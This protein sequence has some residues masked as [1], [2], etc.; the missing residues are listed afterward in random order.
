MDGDDVLYF[1]RNGNGDLTDPEDRI[2]PDAAALKKATRQ[3]D[4]PYAPSHE[5]AIGSVAGVDLRFDF[6]VRKRGFVPR[7]E[8]YRKLMQDRQD[9]NWENGTLWRITGP[10]GAAQNPTLLCAKPADA[11]ITH[12]DG[13]LTFGLKSR[14]KQKLQPWPRETVFD[15][16]IGTAALSPR[17]CPYDMFSPLA[18]SEFPRDVHPVAVFTFPPKS[19][20]QTP[21]VKSI[22][23]DERCCGDTAYARMAVPPEAGEGTATVAVSY[24]NWKDRTVHPAIFQVPIGG[25]PDDNDTEVSYVM[26]HD[27]N[28]TIGLNEAMTAL[29]AR[30]LK[31]SKLSEGKVESLLIE[32]RV[33][34]PAFAIALNRSPDVLAT[35]QILGARTAFEKVLR[36]SNARL[37]IH[38]ASAKLLREQKAMLSR[39]HAALQEETQGI[40]Y[41][42][43]DRQLSGPE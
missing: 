34:E 18:E 20:G 31:V 17:N 33:D 23:L 7:D 32:L 14:A 40:L 24:R 15:V 3:E 27:P 8:R 42:T 22:D 13:P 26:F 9:N 38:I 11:Q 39:I 4:S 25:E 30:G 43:W 5:F 35:A 19:P 6:W 1:D 37:E 21:I 29:R 12:L 41:T 28:Q 10:R 2:A 36:S 16:H